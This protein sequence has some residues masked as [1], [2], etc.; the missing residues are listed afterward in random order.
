MSLDE[1]RAR[2]DALDAQVLELLN[3][4]ARI[5]Q[6]VGR[7]KHS[8]N[9][10]YY[11]PEREKAV[12]E[13]LRSRNQGPLSDDAIRAIYREIISSSRALEKPTTVAFLGPLHTFSQLA[14]QRIFGVTA[15]LHP[16]PTVNDIFNEVE[17]KRIDYG[18]VP[19]ES[20]MGGGVSDTLDRFLGSELKIVNELLLHVSQNLLSRS[21]ID[22]IRTVYSK[23][24]AFPQCRNWLQANLPQAERVNVSSTA[25]AA[26]IA[27]AED[28]A[29]AIGSVLAAEP[30]GLEVVA[31]R[32]E[33]SPHNY[34]RFFAIGRQLVGPSGHDKTSLLISI[35]NKAG[36]LH[37]LL[38]PFAEG[39][40]DLSKIESRPS[41]KK[42]W[43]Y[44]FFIDLVGHVDEPRVK[45]ALEAIAP[46]CTEL[47]VLGSYP[48]GEV[49]S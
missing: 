28:G 11:V 13:K 14:A 38:I 26:R 2:I 31:E 21:P 5:A 46:L 49:E 27:A 47:K 33:D 9:S 8:T 3:E 10:A 32:I 1:L 16:M 15:E 44:V 36:A 43:D 23:E 39:G 29:A 24:Q 12:Y 20:S 48:R 19:A 30:Y 34:T 22:K 25:E 45:K 35:S 7:I 40:I 4:R 42:A 17:R 41:R 6:E 37:H 18:V